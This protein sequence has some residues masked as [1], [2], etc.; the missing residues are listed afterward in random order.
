MKK[1]LTL[2]VENAV[3]EKAKKYAAHNNTSVSQMVE[4]YLE[5]LTREGSRYRP[6]P[7]SWTESLRG[8]A[9]LPEEY[10]NLDY[11][12]IKEREIGRKHGDQG[13]A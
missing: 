13:S 9:K 12:E 2:T 3:K 7:G 11:K 8:S 1:K 5:V 6:D 10:K 4:N